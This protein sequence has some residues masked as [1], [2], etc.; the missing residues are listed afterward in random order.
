MSK[1]PYS[2]QRWQKIRKAKL[3][4]NPLCEAC[5]QIGSIEPAAAVDHRTPIASGG[6]AFP[7]LEGLASLCVRHHNAKT[8]CEQLGESDY[9][10]KGC[11]VFGYPLDPKHPWYRG[12]DGK[13]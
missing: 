1:W 4:L 5:L 8:R 6:E 12:R 9:M 3:R 13:T 10:L 11:D 7:P 2:T